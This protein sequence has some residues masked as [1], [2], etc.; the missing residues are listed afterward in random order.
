MFLNSSL[1]ST[2]DTVFVWVFFAELLIRIVAIGPENFFND[3]WNN[4]DSFLVMFGI[5]FFFI[6]DSTGADSVVRMSRIFRIATLARLISHS[7]F[8]KD[9]NL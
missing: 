3:R 5:T 8:W 1:A 7:N 4:V 2:F 9:F 6:P